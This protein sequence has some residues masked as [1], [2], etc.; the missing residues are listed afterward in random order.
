VSCNVPTSFL[1]SVLRCF[2]REFP[3]FVSFQER[4]FDDMFRYYQFTELA[5]YGMGRCF[6]KTPCM[7]QQWEHEE[8]IEHGMLMGCTSADK[9]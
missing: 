6:D 1:E 9:E 4:F 8:L 2:Y 5:A 3:A 7:K